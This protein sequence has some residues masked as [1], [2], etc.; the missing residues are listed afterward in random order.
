MNVTSAIRLMAMMARRVLP[1][2]NVNDW[3]LGYFFGFRRKLPVAVNDRSALSISTVWACI[4]FISGSVAQLP[5][6]VYQKRSA[7]KGADEMVNHP[8]YW[9]LNVRPNPEMSATVF[10]ELALVHCQLYGNFYAEIERDRAGRPLHLWP[11]HPGRVTAARRETGALYYDI[12]NVG[13]P[14][15]IE[16]EN[17]FHV[18]GMGYDGICGIPVIQ[19]AAR[20]MGLA[21]ASEEY[22]SNFFGNSGIPSAILQHPKLIGKNAQERLLE[23]FRQRKGVT[24]SQDTLILEEGME[25][26][27]IA[28]PPEQAQ[29]LETRRFTVEDICRWFRVPP[30]KVGHFEKISYNSAEQL[31]LD[32][33]GEALMPWVKKFEQEADFKLLNDN[34]SGYFSKI[35]IRA[36]MRSTHAE[37]AKYF[38]DLN[39]IGVLSINDILNLEDMNPI[40]NG[41]L[42]LVPLNMA[43]LDDVAAGKYGPDAQKAAAPA[44]GTEPTKAQPNPPEPPK[45][46]ADEE[47]RNRR[48][49]QWFDSTLD[50]LEE[51]ENSKRHRLTATK[52]GHDEQ[53]LIN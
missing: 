41:D 31:S 3:S 46:S 52:N 2:R 15:E 43:A 19:F 13:D 23:R 1:N 28:L 50:E 16:P 29:F 32:V 34:H 33:I 8:A 9:I 18:P 39:S 40:K 27:P 12:A 48:L 25:Y 26:K 22:G 47:R 5:W 20:T 42:H 14:I 30:S 45:I 17:M 21:L 4:G 11:L 37:R 7:G 38:K 10:R 51:Y 49:L 6:Q 35:D 36:A 53:K 44:P 24:E